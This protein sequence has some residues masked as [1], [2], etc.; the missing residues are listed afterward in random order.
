L[1]R[2][3]NSPAAHPAVVPLLLIHRQSSPGVRR[4]GEALLGILADAGIDGE[5]RV[6]AFRALLSYLVGALSA[7]QLGPARAGVR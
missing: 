2:P 3:R 4:I 7:Q 1:P 6:I 5:R